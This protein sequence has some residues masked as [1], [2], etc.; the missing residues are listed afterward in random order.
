MAFTLLI[1]TAY[2]KEVTIIEKNVDDKLLVPCIR[3]AQYTRLIEVMG[4]KLLNK[5]MS[6]VKNDELDSYPEYKEL[7]N[8]YIKPCL[9]EWSLFEAIPYLNYK[10][11]NGS[12]V[13]KKTDSSD[14]IDLNVVKFLQS[15]VTDSAEFLSERL[16]KQLQYNRTKFPEYCTEDCS[17]VS[18]NE[19]N[20]TTSIYLED[21]NYHNIKNRYEHKRQ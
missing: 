4:E 12:I 7:L 19:S 17:Q 20:Y 6:I 3:I 16:T 2:L 21:Y 1:T 11:E 5:F 9:S 14:P 15:N 8:D 13:T 18:P 10:L